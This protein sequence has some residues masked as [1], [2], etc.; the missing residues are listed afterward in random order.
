MVLKGFKLSYCF[1]LDPRRDMGQTAL[2]AE[3]KVA[4]KSGVTPVSYTANGMK[5][6]DGTELA[7]D[8]IIWCTGYADKNVRQVSPSVFGEGGEQLAAKMD[9][10]W[11]LDKEGEIR[12]LWKRQLNV[13]NFWI[14]GGFTSQHRYYSRFLAIQIKAA[15]AGILPPAYRKV[16]DEV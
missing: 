15:L 12:G 7:S 3:G 11:Q 1:W 6:S 14:M 9:A 2:L 13:D 16:P 4:V 5:L 10:T 8:A